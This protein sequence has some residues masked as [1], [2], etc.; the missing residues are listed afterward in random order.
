MFRVSGLMFGVQCLGFIFQSS[1][2]RV[3]LGVS[4]NL[5]CYIRVPIFGNSD[6]GFKLG[7]RI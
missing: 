1:G 3:Y 5:G 7:V 2:L 4:D 6:L